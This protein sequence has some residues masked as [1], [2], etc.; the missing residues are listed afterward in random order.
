ML[1]RCIG[2]SPGKSNCG[3][4]RRR[5][6][7]QFAVVPLERLEDRFLLSG[8]SAAGL[9][10]L[11]TTP[12]LTSP[13]VTDRSSLAPGLVSTAIQQPNVSTSAAKDR[14][15]RGASSAA[16][17]LPT[18]R[19]AQP[20]GMS[21]SDEPQ[22]GS[23]MGSAEESDP[24]E[25]N[26]LPT[27]GPGTNGSS[28]NK[29]CKGSSSG[30]TFSPEAGSAT[31]PTSSTMTV[32]CGAPIQFPS[33]SLPLPMPPGVPAGGVFKQIAANS[34][35]A[36]VSVLLLDPVAVDPSTVSS[37][38]VTSSSV[39]GTFHGGPTSALAAQSAT[40]MPGVGF[41]K[42]SLRSASDSTRRLIAIDTAAN[43]ARPRAELP[44]VATL[45]AVAMPKSPVSDLAQ[46]ADPRPSIDSMKVPK[47]TTQELVS[48]E[49]S[50]SVM[51][52]IDPADTEKTDRNE[53][54]IAAKIA[55]YSAASLMVG[56]SAP[57][58]TSVIHRG[59]AKAKR[60]L[61]VVTGGRAFG[62]P[63]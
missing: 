13:A 60:R 1:F 45:A 28:L 49:A 63:H 8:V 32:P 46:D 54:R 35:S 43:P 37:G 55:I 23:V 51:N 2:V 25:Q 57:G 21:P 42:S 27:P 52:R 14:A 24:T 10:D 56:V 62:S 7:T 9:S 29:P 19:Q 15:Q 31:V 26:G 50:P 6:S 11:R 34:A 36:N 48:R 40:N 61:T 58:L 17:E 53:K 33:I 59:K 3:A 12:G 18:S 30:Y 41:L 39:T 20:A 44:D 16:A 22:S 47:K 4:L 5:A 38:P